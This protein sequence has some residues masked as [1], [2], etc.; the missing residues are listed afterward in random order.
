MGDPPAATMGVK[1]CGSCG[2]LPKRDS[3]IGEHAAAMESPP[4]IQK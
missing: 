1:E 3:N 2:P 4:T